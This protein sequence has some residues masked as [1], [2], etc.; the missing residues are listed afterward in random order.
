MNRDMTI[1]AIVLA[2]GSSRRMGS[3]N[4]LLMEV[5]GASMVER[6]IQ[7]IIEAKLE[8]IVVVTG[9]ENEKIQSYLSGYDLKFV[10]NERF[11]EGMGTSLA[12]GVE[13]IVAVKPDGMMISLGDLP[14]LKNESVLAVVERF[15]SFG[16]EKI[17]VPVYSGVQGHPIIFPFRYAEELKSLKDD[18]GARYLVRREEGSVVKIELEDMGIVKDVD[19]PKPT[20]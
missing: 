15:C 4:K 6:S 2:A 18:T 13:S 11:E 20:T 5:E 17:V 10:F 8:S 14:Y 19:S 1:C 3:I 12:L 7:P 9:F 16:G